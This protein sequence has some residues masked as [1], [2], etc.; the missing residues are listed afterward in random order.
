MLFDVLFDLSKS[1]S[2]KQRVVF[3]LREYDVS[4]DILLEK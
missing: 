2:E 1:Q 4:L 3:Q